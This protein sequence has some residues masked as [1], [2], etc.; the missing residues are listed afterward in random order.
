MARAKHG[1]G[2]PRLAPEKREVEIPVCV[3]RFEVSGVEVSGRKESVT[4]KKYI[5]RQNL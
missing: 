2:T 1:R 3:H 4:E 5:T